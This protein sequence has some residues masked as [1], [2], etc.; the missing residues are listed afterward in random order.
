MLQYSLMGRVPRHD[1]ALVQLTVFIQQNQSQSLFITPHI[2]GFLSKLRY[3]SL[4]IFISNL[5]VTALSHYLQD[6]QP[7]A[8]LHLDRIL[9]SFIWKKY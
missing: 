1:A 6:V 2:S 9:F 3:L 4:S 7:T 8:L 5:V